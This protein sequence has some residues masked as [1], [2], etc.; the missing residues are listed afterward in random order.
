[1]HAHARRPAR[2]HLHTCARH[3]NAH[4]RKHRHTCIKV[5]LW[6][7]LALPASRA[8]GSEPMLLRLQTVPSVVYELPSLRYLAVPRNKISRFTPTDRNQLCQARPDSLRQFNLKPALC[9]RACVTIAWRCARHAL[10]MGP[11]ERRAT[12]CSTASIADDAA[13]ASRLILEHTE[14]YRPLALSRPT[15]WPWQPLSGLVLFG[16][17][18]PRGGQADR[19]AT[20]RSVRK[21]SDRTSS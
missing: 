21:P 11:A 10:P 1:M 17:V 6:G 14:E 18:D 13:R 3:R 2:T 19:P 8:V 16:R 7:S 20:S 4:A 9:C 15:Q 12:G 5:R